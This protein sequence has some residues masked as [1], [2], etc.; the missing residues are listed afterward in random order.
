MISGIYKISNIIN[1][2]FYIGS[3]TDISGRWRAHTNTLKTKKH[4]NILLQ[5]TYDKYGLDNLKSSRKIKV[6]SLTKDGD[7]DKI[8]DSATNAGKYYNI[9][10]THIIR[11]C[12]GKSISGITHGYGFRYYETRNKYDSKSKK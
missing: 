9:N 1:D 5:R 2:K 8:F 6:C 4:H 3:A 10:S 12:K 7:V 11:I